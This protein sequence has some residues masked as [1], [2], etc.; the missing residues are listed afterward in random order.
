MGLFDK[1]KQGLQ[2]TTQQLKDRLDKLDEMVGLATRPRRARAR[3]TSI[4][5]RSSKRFC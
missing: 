2:K 5:R 4:R 1:L 3:S